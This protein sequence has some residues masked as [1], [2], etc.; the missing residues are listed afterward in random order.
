MKRILISSALI[1]L[2]CVPLLALLIY[3][4]FS[5]GRPRSP[6][7]AYQLVLDWGRLAPFPKSATKL[8]IETSG[9]MFTR[10]FR[11]QF[12]A[13]AKEIE[14]WLKASPGTA[15]VA[16]E[17]V[18]PTKRKYYVTPGKGAEH[19]EVNVDDETHTV[20]IYVYWS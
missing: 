17:Q 4:V 5:P 11:V 15:N 16:P 19:A 10:G 7:T 6:E 18:T 8:S 3:Q 20:N 1:A 2:I 9:S 14:N 13:P 12:Q